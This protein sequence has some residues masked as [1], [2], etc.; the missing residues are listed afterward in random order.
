MIKL[1]TRII[2]ETRM[3]L[4]EVDSVNRKLLII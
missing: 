3:D 2:A 1:G 4:K